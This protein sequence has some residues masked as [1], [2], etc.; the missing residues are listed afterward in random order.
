M[1]RTSGLVIPSNQATPRIVDL[2]TA[3]GF[4]DIMLTAPHPIHH[5]GDRTSV[6][7]EIKMERLRV[8]V[9]GS[10]VLGLALIDGS[11]LANDLAF[12]AFA[13]CY[14][15]CP[16]GPG[17]VFYIGLLLLAL[18]LGALSSVLAVVLALI[19]AG[20]RGDWVS[21]LFV[22]LVVLLFVANV[23][24]VQ[25]LLYKINYGP[26]IETLVQILVLSPLLY[27]LLCDHRALRLATLGTLGA[28]MVIVPLALVGPQL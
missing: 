11:I 17:P 18:A 21:A 26:T 4:R 14:T 24:V 1:K 12:S 27:G 19:H 23:V 8:A 22:L 13:P 16:P 10:A 6:S 9:I 20:R 28:L 7:Q 3:I 2:Y 25:P 5:T 15:S